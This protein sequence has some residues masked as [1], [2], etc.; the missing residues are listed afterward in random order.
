[1]D[2]SLDPLIQ[3]FLEWVARE[4]RPYAEAMD[5]WCT[6]CPRLT[7]WEDAVDRGFVRREVDARRCVVVAPT[8]AGLA[9][10]SARSKLARASAR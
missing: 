8:E 5:A 3:D 10:L 9:F 4:P 2:T 7:V 6:S 1:M